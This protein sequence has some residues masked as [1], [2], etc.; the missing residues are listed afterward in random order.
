MEVDQHLEA[1]LEVVRVVRVQYRRLE[2]E[3]HPLSEALLPLRLLVLRLPLPRHSVPQ[4]RP[5]PLGLAHQ[6]L[7][8]LQ[9]VPLGLQS[10]P[11]RQYQ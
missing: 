5:L 9:L 2:E 10:R 3:L 7:K 1:L 8:D 11:I 4:L 6:R